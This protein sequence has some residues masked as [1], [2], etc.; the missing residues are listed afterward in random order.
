MEIKKKIQNT[1]A[2]AQTLIDQTRMTAGG[3]WAS[4]ICK[5]PQNDLMGS[6]EV[7]PLSYKPLEPSFRNEAEYWDVPMCTCV[8]TISLSVV[9]TNTYCEWKYIQ[10]TLHHIYVFFNY[11][12]VNDTPNPGYQNLNGTFPNVQCLVCVPHFG[13]LTSPWPDNHYPGFCFFPFFRDFIY[14][15]FHRCLYL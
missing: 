8:C 1:D 4:G 15:F 10:K 14:D 2:W 13:A 7:K 11:N 6:S 9:L 12:R 3:T 5:G